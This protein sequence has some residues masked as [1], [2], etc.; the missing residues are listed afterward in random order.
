MCIRD[1]CQGQRLHRRRH[2]RHAGQIDRG[3]PHKFVPGQSL[4]T[5][6]ATDED[7]AA[8]EA[9]DAR[10]F[11]AVRIQ[12][13]GRT[14]AEAVRYKVNPDADTAQLASEAVATLGEVNMGCLLY[15]SRCV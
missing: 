7:T 5:A 10:T 9:A 15:T 11:V 14:P 12:P 3:Q 8:A 2:H 1:R 13:G 4:R 6:A